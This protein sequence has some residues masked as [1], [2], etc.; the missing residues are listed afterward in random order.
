MNAAE[1]GNIDVAR[2]LIEKGADV[3]ASNKDGVPLS[4]LNSSLFPLFS[5]SK[6][7]ISNNYII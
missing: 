5:S 4:S 6:L 3:N 2:V 1:A 7:Y